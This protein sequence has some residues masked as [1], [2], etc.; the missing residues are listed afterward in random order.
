MEFTAQEIQDMAEF[1]ARRFP[2]AAEREA[3][4]AEAGLAHGPS[5]PDPLRAWTTTLTAAASQHKVRRLA[6]A[7]LARRAGDENLVEMVRVLSRERRRR[8]GI[9][10]GLV[11]A[12]VLLLV[13]GVLLWT[14]PR[15]ADAPEVAPEA[16][17]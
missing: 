12:G 8:G 6:T 3:I 5:E 17:P 10:W 7:A 14:G 16:A 4:M 1:F 9:T 11:G 15:P 2:Q 13:G